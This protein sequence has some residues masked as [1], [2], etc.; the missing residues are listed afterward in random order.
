MSLDAMALSLECLAVGERMHGWLRDLFPVCR[1]LTGP[2]VR[3]TLDYL[4]ERLP[5]LTRHSVESGTKVFDWV[6]PPEWTIRSATLLGPDGTVVADL[7]D[8]TLHVMGYSRPVD[9]ELDLEELQPHLHSLPEQP[10]AIPFVTSYYRESWGFCLTHRQRSAL[11]PGRY[12]ARIDSTLGPGRL[13]YADLVI[14][15]ESRDEVLLSTYVCHPSMA[16]N[17]LSGPV[18][19]TALGQWLAARP[20]RRLTYRIVFVPETIGSIVY[21]SQHLDHLHQRMVAGFVMTCCGDER[22][23]SMVQSPYGDTL[24]DRVARHV[25]GRLAPGYI[26]YPFTQRGSDERQYCSPGVRLPVCSV[27][28]SKHSTYPEYHTSLDDDRLVTPVGLAGSYALYRSMIEALESNCVP[29]SPQPC[30]PQLGRR[31]LYPDTSMKGSTGAVRL[32]SDILAYSD[33]TN[34]LLA[35][36]DMLGADILECRPIVDRLVAAGVLRLADFNDAGRRG[37]SM[38]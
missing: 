37:E 36:A 17:E 35:I 16:N 30:E 9:V 19:A 3:Q 22:A 15:G 38:G 4:G 28:R 11:P 31:G 12:R 26:A 2:G 10:D 8:H 7:R 29:D 20:T 5:G 14:P 18:L 33:G 34:D 23:V 1:S 21:L 32:Q 6:V 25:L 13:D 27:M 24:A